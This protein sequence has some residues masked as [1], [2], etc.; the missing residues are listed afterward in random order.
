MHGKLRM[1]RIFSKLFTGNEFF[2]VGLK[3][4]HVSGGSQ[5]QIR[6]IH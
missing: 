3:M 5:I 4:K 1:F 6:E 2:M